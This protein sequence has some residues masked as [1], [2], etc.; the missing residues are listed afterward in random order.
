MA[1]GSFETATSP[2][3]VWYGRREGTPPAYGSTDRSDPIPSG[4]AVNP[5]ESDWAGGE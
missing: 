4:N 3:Y 1:G 2:E 5:G